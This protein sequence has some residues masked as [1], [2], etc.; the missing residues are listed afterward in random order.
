MERLIQLRANLAIL[1]KQREKADTEPI[2]A[3]IQGIRIGNFVL[4]TFPGEPFAEIG[5]RIKERSPFEFTF[6]AAYTNGHIGYP[7]SQGSVLPDE[8]QRLDD[9]GVIN[10]KHVARLASG[11][12]GWLDQLRLL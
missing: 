9:I 3:E 8:T 1:Q 6:L 10:G 5:L 4:L 11:Q 2:L 12:P 7:D